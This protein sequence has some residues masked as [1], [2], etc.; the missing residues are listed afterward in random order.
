MKPDAPPAAILL[1]GSEQG[2]IQEEAEAIKRIVLGD[3]DETFSLAIFH[4]TELDEEQFATTCREIPFLTPRRLVWLK[5]TESLDVH[6]RKRLVEYLKDPVLSTVLLMTGD[7]LEA[8]NPLRRSMERNKKG[9]CIPFY[10]LEGGAF[11]QWVRS[12][13]SKARVAI[14][15]DALQF[16]SHHLEGN[17][18]IAEGELEKVIL[19][20]GNDRTIRLNDL[21]ALSKGLQETDKFSW[22]TSCFNGKISET[23]HDLDQLL[24]AG[25]APLALL[26]LYLRHLRRLIEGRDYLRQGKQPKVIARKMRVFWKE[27]SIFFSQC[28]RWNNR[29]LAQ[30]ILHCQSLDFEL[31]HSAKQSRQL[32]HALVFKTAR[33]LE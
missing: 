18:A 12:R 2:K 9:W 23:I 19:R 14:E 11:V 7:A 6:A 30:L 25:E 1:Y 13:L 8:N 20:V 29:D 32:M 3:G 33:L 10:P 28:K 26:G 4:A 16:L 15:P 27:E 24:D 21:D 17:T 22:V 31:R 5:A